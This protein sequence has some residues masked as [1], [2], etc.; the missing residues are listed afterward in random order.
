[1]D[2]IY[3]LCE[4]AEEQ[5]TLLKSLYADGYTRLSGRIEKYWT[6][7]GFPGAVG[8]SLNDKIITGGQC[9]ANNREFKVPL[10]TF[11]DIEE[12]G[13]IELSTASKLGL[14]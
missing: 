2:K 1:M 10:L 13:L 14:L 11:D 7:C 5:K 3:I 9:D 4:N 8:V 12:L 6:F